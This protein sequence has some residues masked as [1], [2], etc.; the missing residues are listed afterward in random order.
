EAPERAALQRLQD[1]LASVRDTLALR[2][3]DRWLEAGAGGTVRGGGLLLR[4]SLV[5]IR[6]GQLGDGWNLGSAQRLARRATK[7][8]PDWPAAWYLSGLAAQ[9]LGR[10]RAETGSNLG[11]RVGFSALEGAARQY[12]RA[13]AI[14]P[15]YLPALRALNEVASVLQDTTLIRSSVLP[16]FR[17]ASA[18]E[19]GSDAAILLARGRYERLMG[20]ADS[21]LAALRLYADLQQ[22]SGTALHELAWSGALAGETDAVRIYYEGSAFDDSAAVAAY[23][24]DVELLADDSTLAAFDSTQG[25]GRTEFLRRFWTLRD[26]RDLRSEGQRLVEHFHRRTYAE[27]HFALLTNRRLSSIDDIYRSADLPFDDRGM[28]YLRQG[29][30]DEVIRPVLAGMGPNET[31]VY[32]RGDGDLLLHF[33]GGGG[34]TVGGDIQ[35]YRLVRSIFELGAG[36]EAQIEMLLASRADLLDVYAKF[37]NWGQYARA[38]AA[39]REQEIVEGSIEVATVTDANARHYRR[40]VESAA[41]AV[42]IGELDGSPVVHLVLAIPLEDEPVDPNQIHLPVTI[43]VGFYDVAGVPGPALDRDT[44][45]TVRRT[46]DGLEAQGRLEFA[47]SPGAW[48]YRVSVETND[49][50]GRILPEDSIRVA[51]VTGSPLSLSGIALGTRS[52]GLEWVTAPGD[53]AVANPSATFDPADQVE[54]YFEAYGL[55]TTQPVQTQVR[56]TQGKRDALRL[57]YEQPVT[58]TPLRVRRSLDIANVKP[59]KYRLEVRVVTQDGV[60]ATSAREIEVRRRGSR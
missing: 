11:T 16:A 14:D 17:H 46:D 47:V 60:E 43:R 55:E 54:M 4:R 40:S 48:L 33:R 37:L 32:R 28:V 39:D 10:W 15:G 53:T 8:E 24:S 27:R 36:S 6:M 13:L 31:W 59:G 21:S 44:V 25:E 20:E 9:E 12:L 49:S 26:R 50:T 56:I 3:L 34:Y 22:R 45:L 2:R 5:R 7:S 51:P 42:A 38:R 58:G 30:P 19:T 57:S 29:E 23:R 18:T 52:K 35:D 41:D 1:S